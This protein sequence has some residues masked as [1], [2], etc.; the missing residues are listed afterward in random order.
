M[1]YAA[2]SIGIKLHLSFVS[3]FCSTTLTTPTH[4]HLDSFI[5]T[6]SHTHTLSLPSPSYSPS[7]THIIPADNLNHDLFILTLASP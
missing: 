6:Y 1:T 3:G 5:L 7:H 4:T 2:A